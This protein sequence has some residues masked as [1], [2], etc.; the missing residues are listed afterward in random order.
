MYGDVF[1]RMK[2]NYFFSDQPFFYSAENDTL[3][4]QQAYGE[5]FNR[6]GKVA[7]EEIYN[8]SLLNR[9]VM[10]EDQFYV[11]AQTWKW[12]RSK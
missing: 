2:F 3:T 5:C 7:H 4:W 11:I 10:G 9:V 1:L 8:Q 12:I 6:I